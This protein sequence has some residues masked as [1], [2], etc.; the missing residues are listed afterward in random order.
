MT[1]NV[2]ATIYSMQVDS[3]GAVLQ[4]V[5]GC[6]NLCCSR[7]SQVCIAQHGTDRHIIRQSYRFQDSN[8]VP[9]LVSSLVSKPQ[10]VTC[11]V[12]QE[13]D[14]SIKRRGHWNLL[15]SGRSP[16][17]R[18][19]IRERCS[20]ATGEHDFHSSVAQFKWR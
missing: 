7:L 17:F 13:V 20:A 16:E 4:S 11:K 3:N 15:V 10:Q 18:I 19:S 12:M 1:V 6:C 5:V 9:N 2:N 14:C 8:L